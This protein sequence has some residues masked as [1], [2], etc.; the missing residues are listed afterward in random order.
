MESGS[1]TRPVSRRDR[2]RGSEV[3]EAALMFLP[4]FALVFLIIDTAWVLFIKATIQYAAHEGVRYAVT[5]QISPGNTQEASIKSV[6]QQESLSLLSPSSASAITVTFLDANTLQPS[7]NAPGNIVQVSATY[8]F[9]P[10]A[11][12]FRSGMQINLNATS[13][14]VLEGYS[15]GTPP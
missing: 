5:G 12:L 13:A 9:S 15:R 14:D 4:F 3:V 8:A 2:R 10:L 6:V 11:P 7:T 1:R